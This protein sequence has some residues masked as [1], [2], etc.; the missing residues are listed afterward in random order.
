MSRGELDNRFNPYGLALSVLKTAK[1]A[2]TS[3]DLL[4]KGTQTS[5]NG[6]L[7]NVIKL[8]EDNNPSNDIAVCDKLS[9]FINQVD[10]KEGN[11][12]LTTQQAEELRQQATSIQHTLG[13][14]PPPTSPSGTSQ[15]SVVILPH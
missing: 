1:R 8:L 9:S 15:L 13:C 7:H 4:K 11:R 3:N 6:P 5:L 10:A 12:Q 2:A 14:P